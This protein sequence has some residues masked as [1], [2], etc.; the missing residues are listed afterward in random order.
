[1][2]PSLFYKPDTSADGSFAYSQFYIHLTCFCIIYWEKWFLAEKKKRVN[3]WWNNEG[4]GG[5]ALSQRAVGVSYSL[6]AQ[7]DFCPCSSLLRIKLDTS[8]H[9]CT[10]ISGGSPTRARLGL[11]PVFTW[12]VKIQLPFFLHLSFDKSQSGEI[13]IW[14]VCTEPLIALS[15][16]EAVIN[17]NLL[18]AQMQIQKSELIY[19]A[20]ISRGLWNRKLSTIT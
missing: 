3:V 4:A 11:A 6:G 7:P 16:W 1:M 13:L 2:S 12:L 20:G 5:A 10:A 18:N 15:Q 9:I 19:F 14:N 8:Q 17:F